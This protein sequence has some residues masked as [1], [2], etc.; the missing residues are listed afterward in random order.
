METLEPAQ[1]TT[2]VEQPVGESVV[3]PKNQA[4]KRL[5]LIIAAAVIV[6]GVGITAV[7]MRSSGDSPQATA[8]PTAEATA[9]AA[10]E[11]T[12]KSGGSEGDNLMGQDDIIVADMTKDGPWKQSLQ[13]SESKDGKTFGSQKTFQKGGGV[14]TAVRDQA[15][16]LY[17]AFQYF[18]END[19]QNFDKIAIKKSTDAGVTW[20]EPIPAVFTNYPKAYSRPFDHTLAL[21]PEGKIRM[22]YTANTSSQSIMTKTSDTVAFYSSI[23]A[24]GVTYEFEEGKRLS[25]PGKA[26][27]D[28]AASYHDGMWYLIASTPK[29]FG[30]DGIY[31]AS[32]STDG[33]N[34]ATP[35]LIPDTKGYEWTG[36]MAKVGSALRFYGSGSKVFYSELGADG[37]WG[38]AVNTNLV[39]GDPAIVQASEGKYF[40][41]FSGPGAP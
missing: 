25:V 34:F 29:E 24:D 1:V 19:P 21:T 18:P 5:W 27:I 35:T 39:G 13:I 41:I 9:Q 8:T 15:G 36:N 33:L 17:A 28:S 20:S 23:S 11:V 16:V 22:Y 4:P 3:T 2:A 30:E 10:K 12:K 37:A 6:L 7:A 31:Y 40:A 26:I 32:T 38:K 14:V